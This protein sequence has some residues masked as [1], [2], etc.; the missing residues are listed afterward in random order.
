MS[1]PSEDFDNLALDALI[2]LVTRARNYPDW[3]KEL[4]AFRL[5]FKQA[6]PGF[7]R[8]IGESIYGY[9][10]TFRE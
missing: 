8:A 3:K 9:K 1:N 2:K 10:S 6:S 7:R 5:A 4:E